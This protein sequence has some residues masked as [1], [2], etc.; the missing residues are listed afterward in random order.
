MTDLQSQRGYP[1][2]LFFLLLAAAILSALA[3]L[4]Y[5]MGLL[6]EI[7]NAR[8][9]PPL[10]LPLP[11]L[12]VL[13][14]TVNFGVAVG[15]GLLFARQLGLGAPFLENWLYEEPM[16]GLGRPLVI[17]AVVGCV[18]GIV[19]YVIAMSPIGEPI[20]SLPMSETGLPVWKRFLACFYGAIGEEILTRLFCLSLVL[21]VLTK[22]TLLMKRWRLGDLPLPADNDNRRKAVVFWIA[23]VVVAVLFGLGHLPMAMALT[24]VTASLVVLIVSLN[25]F[26]G[27]GFGYLYWRW[28]LEAAMVGHFFADIMLHLAGPMVGGRS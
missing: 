1:W 22:A 14:A 18:L 23:N 21:W 24:H 9:M 27:L 8:P 2:R 26:V 13:Q 7:L 17:G 12:V 20:R 15:L 4:P 3:V 10:A 5:V 16:T 28:C 19:T 25:A 11:V 6:S